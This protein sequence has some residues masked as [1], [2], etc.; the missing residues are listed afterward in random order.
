MDLLPL[1]L[2]V[3]LQMEFICN[4]EL[5]GVVISENITYR[6]IMHSHDCMFNYKNYMGLSLSLCFFF[7]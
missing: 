6:S 1:I 3:D 7:Y 2:S 4:K 5:N